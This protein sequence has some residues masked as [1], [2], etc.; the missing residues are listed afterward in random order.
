[1]PATRG[2][3]G[4]GSEMRKMSDE[5]EKLCRDYLESW[6]LYQSLSE[7]DGEANLDAQDLLRDARERLQEYFGES[8]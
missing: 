1:M 8:K 4:S 6:E 5:L 3:M 7:T 2:P